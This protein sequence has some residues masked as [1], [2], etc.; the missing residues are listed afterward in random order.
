MDNKRK[1]Y[2]S[3]EL[4]SKKIKME[5]DEFNFD[6]KEKLNSFNE[7]LYKVNVLKDRLNKLVDKKKDEKLQDDILEIKNAKN[8]IKSVKHNLYYNIYY[9]NKLKNKLEELQTTFKDI[10]ENLCDH[11]IYSECE[12]HN[13][14]YY[15]CK[16]CSYEK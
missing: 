13:D 6:G 10:S 1:I 9:L 16:K 12:Y 15:Y 2:T 14:R 11:D 5:I 3:D 4:S 8:D 7:Y